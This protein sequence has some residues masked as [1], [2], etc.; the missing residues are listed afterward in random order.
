MTYNPF[1]P[2]RPLPARVGQLG[3]PPFPGPSGT[4]CD[5]NSIAMQAAAAASGQGGSCRVRRAILGLE[6]LTVAANTGFTSSTQPQKPFRGLRM[7]IGTNIAA[8]LVVTDVTVSMMPQLAS[9]SAA[10]PIP[11]L[12]FAETSVD[13]AFDDFDWCPTSE[14]IKVTGSN[15]DANAVDYKAALLGLVLES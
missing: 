7:I 5:T 15:I 14:K 4:G 12:V 2:R 3:V 8:K 13:S 11:G 10:Q 1:Q 9:N 6:A